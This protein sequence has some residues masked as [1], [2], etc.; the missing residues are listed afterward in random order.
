MTT[1]Q[2][3]TATVV[4]TITGAGN[5]TVVITSRD[6]SNSPKTKSVAMTNGWTASQVA[7]AIR[8]ALAYDADVAEFFLVSGS[9]ANVVL[10][11]H[12]SVAND[13]TL[14]ISID[15]GTC[16]GLT[17]AATSTNTTAGDGIENGY[18]TLAELK[19]SDVL[20]FSDTTHDAVLERE[21]E[22][23][24]RA[25]D[26][27]C[28]RFFYAITPA[29]A[30]YY[31][32]EEA[33]ILKVDD[34]Y[35]TTGMTVKADYNGDGTFE[36]TF[37]STDYNVYPYSPPNGKPYTKLEIPPSGSYTF[38]LGPKGIEVTALF[39]WSSVPS[40]VNQACVMLAQRLHKRNQTILGQAAASAV[41]TISL[42]IPK[43]DPDVQMLLMPY[44]KSMT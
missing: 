44:R 16:T 19:A 43:I 41:G 17:T 14:N 12:V 15:N 20:N 31:S 26:E 32:A 40:A 7:D 36:T 35:S 38:P 39:G 11:R 5:A 4:G 24:S 9:S 10:T 25:I 28:G 2:V 34:I 3:E 13:T 23:A 33:Y 18:A 42:K 30:H 8:D 37:A 1:Q 21:I 6:M 27:Y 22:A 29:E